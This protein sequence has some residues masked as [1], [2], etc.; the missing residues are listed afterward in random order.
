V[1]GRFDELA[2]EFAERYRRGE[3]PSVEEY[4][5][6]LPE[7][8]EEIREMLP[9]LVE[10]EQVEGDAREHALQQQSPPAGPRLGQIGDY[11]ILREV[12]RGGMRVLYE[13][14]QVSLGR[15]V[16]LKVLPRQV[17]LEPT[18]LQR[19][20]GEAKSA[21]RIH[22]TNIVPVF[23]VGQDSET[24]YHAMQ[25]I[26]GPG[27]DQVIDELARVR[28]DGRL[29]TP[30]DPA[31]TQG[32]TADGPGKCVTGSLA[33]SLLTG[34]LATEAAA[35]RPADAA[36]LAGT[37]RFDPDATSATE[38]MDPG[39]EEHAPPAA[40][41]SGVLPGGSSIDTTAL[42]GSPATREAL[43]MRITRPAWQG[44]NSTLIAS[45][46]SCGSTR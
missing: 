32:P 18:A 15:R 7:I 33:A 26:Q 19:F 2:E 25:F 13:A 23:E 45:V 12:G 1:Y 4:I 11:R 5:D 10:V 14:E 6:R 44:S 37:E 29:R 38:A 17:A 9:A 36:G 31:P 39:Q 30:A 42:F 28:A 21:A 27:L 43:V 8:A 46:R 40:P 3:R 22:H 34:R 41:L 35:S 24:A 20:R 16:A